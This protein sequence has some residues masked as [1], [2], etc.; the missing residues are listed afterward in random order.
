MNVVQ[1]LRAPDV[2]DFVHRELRLDLRER[3]PVAVVVVADVMVIKLGRRGAFGG[4]AER[5]S[6]QSATMSV[7]S[8]L[9]EG[10][11]R[12]ITLSRI[13]LTSGVFCEVNL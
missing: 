12:M 2:V 1:N 4:R 8:G 10:T 9:S 11:S 7:P 13:S 5:L 6:Y 3:V